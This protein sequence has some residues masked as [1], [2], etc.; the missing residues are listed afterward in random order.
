MGSQE[1]SKKKVQ[2]W[3]KAIVHF[4]LC[5]VM[6][7]FTGFAPTSKSSIFS[8]HVTMS[9]STSYSPQPMEVL[10]QSRTQNQNRSLLDDTEPAVGQNHSAKKAV[11]PQEEKREIEEFNPRRLVIVVTPTS[12]RNKLREVLLRRLANTLRLVAQPLLW[13]VVEQQSNESEVSEILRKTGIMY[14][15]VVFKEN[16]TDAHSEMDHQRNLALN[17]IEHHRLSGIVHFAGLS[18]VYDLS[19]FEE[20]RGIEAFGAWPIAK[21]SAN[22]KKVVIEGPVCDSSEVMG[23]HLK[24]MQNVTEN[25]RTPP[26]HISSFA[27]NSSILWDPERWG[28]TSSAQDTSQNSVKYVREE[29]LEE[30]TKLKGIPGQGCSKVLLW[31]F[32]ISHK[33]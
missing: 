20:I 5:F 1:R 19:F 22:R 25:I 9:L 27:F 29:V 13:V 4:M 7:F 28:R 30:E 15:H 16:F 31:D 23:W 14:R 12:T 32:H 2:L 8:S 11:V 18:N 6:G 21:L 33:M 24:K 10:H 26:I 3:K 17:H